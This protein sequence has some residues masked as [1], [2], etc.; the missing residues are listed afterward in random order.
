MRQKKFIIGKEAAQDWVRENEHWE[1]ARSA[2]LQQLEK[3][4]STDYNQRNFEAWKE[5]FTIPG[6]C[7]VVVV[8]EFYWDDCL[9]LAPH[10]RGKVCPPHWVFDTETIAVR[11]LE[12]GTLL[13]PYPVYHNKGKYGLTLVDRV[14][15]RLQDFT[16][17][18]KQT[19]NY[20][21]K[22][23][24]KKILD[25]VEY[26]SAKQEA[27][28]KF[29]QVAMN[30]NQRFKRAV[31]KRFPDADMDIAQ[32][33]GWLHECV[34]SHGGVRYTFSARS[35]GTFCRELQVDINSVPSVEELLGIDMNQDE[36]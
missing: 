36:L 22:P 1:G 24:K 7:D 30:R 14:E 13:R 16:W 4:F 32:T 35:N 28:I 29:L 34:F 17:D 3:V 19:P 2:I 25:W 10:I 18:Y 23:T 8:Y 20:I 21:G 11:V 33:D 5:I 27:A 9:D 6:F 26:L 31:K 12:T 15:G